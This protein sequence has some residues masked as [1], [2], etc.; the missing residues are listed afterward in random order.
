MKVLVL[1]NSDIEGGAARANFRLF[2][3]IKDI[4]NETYM[5]TQD[6]DTDESNII[7]IY[8]KLSKYINFAKYQLD[9]LPIRFY[10]KRENTNFST[11]LLSSKSIKYIKNLKPEIIHLSW[12]CKGFLPIHYLKNIKIPI[13]W[14]L[15][16]MWAFTGGC[17]YSG[18]CEKYINKCGNCPQIKSRTTLDISRIIWLRKL[19]AW[20]DINLT[21]VTPSN[22][23]A[24][25]AKQ[26][27]LFKDKNIKVIHN[28][29]DLNLFKPINKNFAR[30]ILKLPRDKKLLMFGA[31]SAINDERK[32][33]KYLK[34]AINKIYSN[35]KN[36]DELEIVIFGASKP[37]EPINFGFNVTYLG[38]LRDEIVM[39]L[40][41]SAADVFIAPSKEDNLPN[42]IMEALACGT[43]C[44]AFD[45]GGISDMIIHKKNGY[46]VNPFDIDD[47]MQSIIWVLE[48][49]DIDNKLSFNARKKVEK[50]FNIINISKE[51]YYL[52]KD[53][54]ESN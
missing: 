32:G 22:W 23:L 15:H 13:I 36:K 46:L 50:D 16:D 44:I 14:T 28:G 4:N 35:Y 3:A 20:K 2:K 5:L 25:L 51:Y 26:S 33:F 49:N 43:P 38:I 10:T 52:Y 11:G 29:L 24:N 31:T 8:P 17:H 34:D 45:I 48:E 40:I 41:Y 27:S 18:E 30:D 54:L 6:K 19:F 47:L 12:I 9:Y 39:P 42:T 53:L 7:S 1:N 37:N 21:I